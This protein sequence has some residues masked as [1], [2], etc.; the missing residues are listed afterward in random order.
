MTRYEIQHY[1]DYH[2]SKES[3]G[4]YKE[5]AEGTDALLALSCVVQEIREGKVGTFLIIEKK[6]GKIMQIIGRIMWPKDNSE[7]QMPE[8]P[9]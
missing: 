6:E 5:L 2:A 1:E 9:V 4:T 8:N 3:R 7:G